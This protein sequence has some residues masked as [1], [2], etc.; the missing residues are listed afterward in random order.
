M[1][2]KKNEICWVTITIRN[3]LQFRDSG[4]I[5][6]PYVNKKRLCGIVIIM[7]NFS[8]RL[9]FWMCLRTFFSASNV[10][11][12]VL[13]TRFASGD[14]RTNQLDCWRLRH[15]RQETS[16][17][18]KVC[19]LEGW[20]S[21]VFSLLHILLETFTLAVVFCAESPVHGMR[22]LVCLS[23]G[24]RN[25]RQRTGIRLRRWGCVDLFVCRLGLPGLNEFFF[26]LASAVD[27]RHPG[28]LAWLSVF[29][30]TPSFR[31][32][33]NWNR[34]TSL[35]FRSSIS[36][37]VGNVTIKDEEIKIRRDRTAILR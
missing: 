15:W 22:L 17:L 31:W 36:H 2:K 14:W 29:P 9:Y 24:D 13:I 4:R 23:Y 5:K 21:S 12:S 27:A 26:W 34:F 7:D 20:R 1:V 18:L 33:R 8:C 35:S 11:S 30:S 16:H 32:R 25:A 28:D 19:V 6:R 3:K 10:I 37:R